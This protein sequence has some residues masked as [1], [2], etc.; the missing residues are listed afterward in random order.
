M[1]LVRPHWFYTYILK[2]EKDGGFYIFDFGQLKSKKSRDYCVAE[3]A[4]LAK[5]ITVH[6]YDLSLQA[7]YPIRQVF[8]IGNEELPKPFTAFTSSFVDFFYF[9]QTSNRTKPT[10]KI[11][12][13]IDEVTKKLSLSMNIENKMLR[14]LRRKKLFV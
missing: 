5:P 13:K 11:K 9:L 7:S 2:S 6:D 8:N 14:L 3:V 10:A 12:K 4:K 1:N